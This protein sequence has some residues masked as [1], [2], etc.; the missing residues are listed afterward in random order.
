MEPARVKTKYNS[1]VY[2]PK[3]SAL[4]IAVIN[5]IVGWRISNRNTLLSSSFGSRSLF[6]PEK[7]RGK[8]SYIVGTRLRNGLYVP[9]GCALG[10]IGDTDVASA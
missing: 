10:R 1:G 9:L 3:K 6:R 2:V 8:S 5:C 7:R 4:K